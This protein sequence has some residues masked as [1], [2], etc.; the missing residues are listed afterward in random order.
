MLL[1]Q[2]QFRWN[3]WESHRKLNRFVRGGTKC[4]HQWNAGKNA[5][6]L[7][8]T[9]SIA[10][11]SRGWSFSWRV[12]ISRFF[13]IQIWFQLCSLQKRR[14]STFTSAAPFWQDCFQLRWQRRFFLHRPPRP[15]LH[16]NPESP[17]RR[18]EVQTQAIRGSETLEAIRPR[19]ENFVLQ[20]KT[21]SLQQ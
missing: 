10:H 2:A 1:E 11:F 12:Q 13:Q 7:E 16:Q 9:S 21:I 3:H 18:L 5:S 6:H 20:K 4:V 14:E 8:E 17:N 19:Q 15:S